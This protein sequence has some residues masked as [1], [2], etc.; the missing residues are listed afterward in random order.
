M[1]LLIILVYDLTPRMN[2]YHK[3]PVPVTTLFSAL[4]LDLYQKGT[5]SFTDMKPLRLAVVFSRILRAL[6]QETLFAG[7][8]KGTYYYDVRGV[9]VCGTNFMYQ[10]M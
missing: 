5:F 7:T 2:S 1:S 6:A 10:N 8:G 3:D 9:Q 4:R